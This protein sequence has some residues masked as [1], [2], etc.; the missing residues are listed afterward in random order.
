MKP[1]RIWFEEEYGYRNYIWIY[2]GTKRE[3]INDYVAGK[4]PFR[5]NYNG[6]LTEISIESRIRKPGV[7]YIEFVDHDGEVQPERAIADFDGEIHYHEQDDSF[8]KIDGVH[9]EGLPGRVTLD[10]VTALALIAEDS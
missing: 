5:E 3:L 8:L 10:T 1:L 4:A 9:L 6:F 2:P 7:N